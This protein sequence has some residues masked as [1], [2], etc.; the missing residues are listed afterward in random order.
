MTA[1]RTPRDRSGMV[2]CPR[3][4]HGRLQPLDA[5]SRFAEKCRFD[6]HTGCVL[7]AGGRTRG[8]GNT[9]QY[10]AFWYGGRR[11]FAHRWAAVFIHRL[12]VGKLQVGHCCP[13]GP[14]PLCVQHVMGQTIADN[15]A[16]QMDRLGPPRDRPRGWRAE[17]SAATRQRW[18]LIEKG[19]E[20][21]GP[22]SPRQPEPF[23][24]FT[25]PEWLAPF[26]AKPESVECPF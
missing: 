24:F 17:Q 26:M 12:D 20:E 16:E 23:P 13:A 1:P 15:V 18:L 2:I 11:W 10:G 7:W 8:R 19:Y 14:F 4:A 25:P 6:P 21:L 3:D 9:A 5:L 22:E